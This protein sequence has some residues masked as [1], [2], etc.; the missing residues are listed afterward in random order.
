M[1]KTRRFRT[2]E[3]AVAF[4]EQETLPEP[5]M[6]SSPVPEES[7]IGDSVYAYSTSSG[8]RY[9]FVFRQSDGTLSS[10]FR[11]VQIGPRLGETLQ[12]LR[13]ERLAHDA[14]DVGWSFL[15]P[16][17]RRG[18]YAGRTKP[19]P[20]HRKTVH[21]WHEAALQ[22][23]A[24]RDMPL[25]SL[26]HSAAAAWLAVGHSLI[27]VQRQLGHRSITTTE[28]HYGHLGHLR[29]SYVKDAAART[30]AAIILNL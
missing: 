6:P 23:A 1:Q 8:V 24:M 3:K 17:P 2:R 29:G 7:A 30:E 22:D 25:H 19:I 28:E 20:P 27:F 10:R 15:C 13:H 9:R 26:R 21:V 4:D 11:S 18:R 16:P 14:D 12:A 5:G